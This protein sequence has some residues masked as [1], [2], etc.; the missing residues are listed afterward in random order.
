MTRK[1]PQQ[2]Q[3]LIQEQ[4][5]SDLSI[6]AFC[7]Q[8]HLST[9]SFYSHKAR[10]IQSADTA[11]IQAAVEKNVTHSLAVTEHVKPLAP[12]AELTFHTQA[13]VLAFPQNTPIDQVVALI[14]GLNL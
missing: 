5:Q 1:T 14:R 7:Q 2:W 10:C 4:A 8:H 9:S 12:S 13:G 6:K 11:F 3:S